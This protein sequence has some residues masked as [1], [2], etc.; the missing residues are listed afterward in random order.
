MEE[1]TSY[2]IVIETHIWRDFKSKCAKEGK[3]MIDVLREFI[4]NFINS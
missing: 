2:K 1:L 3:S 4:I